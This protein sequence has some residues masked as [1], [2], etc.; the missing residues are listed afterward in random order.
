LKV[1]TAKGGKKFKP[2]DFVYVRMILQLNRNG[3]VIRYHGNI[4]SYETKERQ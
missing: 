3:M 1:I 2:G 4:D